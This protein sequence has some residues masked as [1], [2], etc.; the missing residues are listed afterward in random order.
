M[1]KEIIVTQGEINA[2]NNHLATYPAIQD[3]FRGLKIGRHIATGGQAVVYSLT[4]QSGKEEYV[5]KVLYCNDRNID[6]QKEIKTRSEKI[7][8]TSAAL[9]ELGLKDYICAVE[10]RF[11]TSD[12]QTYCLI[13]K[14]RICLS[15]YIKKCPKDNINQTMVQ[16]AIHTAVAL[17]GILCVCEKEGILH[18]DIKLDNLFLK[19]TKISDGLCLGDFGCVTCIDDNNFL[20]TNNGRGTGPYKAP[21]LVTLE[22][23]RINSTTV[24]LR[25]SD[26]YSLGVLLFYLCSNAEYPFTKTEVRCAMNPEIRDNIRRLYVKSEAVSEEFKNIIATALRYNP[27]DRFQSCDDMATALKSTP[28]YRQYIEPFLDEPKTQIYNKSKNQSDNDEIEQLLIL[29]NMVE[30]LNKLVSKKSKSSKNA[31]TEPN[32]ST[33]QKSYKE[34]SITK[35]E[36]NTAT[37]NKLD[38]LKSSFGTQEKTKPS[39]TRQPTYSQINYDNGDIY[40]GDV[41]NGKMHG[42]GTYT[43][44][45]GDIYIGDFA[46]NEMTGFCKFIG[47]NKAVYEGCVINGLWNH[48]IKITYPDSGIYE[49]AYKNGI[50]QEE[51]RLIRSF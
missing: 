48:I 24:D 16:I 22:D 44:S 36:I 40:S 11:I 51:L 28:E 2:I 30:E 32:S 43:W 5:I 42:K 27:K 23:F 14:R 38:N 26:M 13:E 46:N 7:H 4:D 47:A 34:N 17:L 33:T 8:N 21:E 19:G 20:T 3:R 15:D 10:Q 29:E 41:L 35:D 9:V 6:Q 37:R 18:R 39:T 45:N 1:P 49:A 31:P 50:R 12:P 25:K